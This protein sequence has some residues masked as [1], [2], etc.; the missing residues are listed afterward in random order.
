MLVEHVARFLAEFRGQ[1]PD[2]Q[3]VGNVKDLGIPPAWLEATVQ[4]GV[5]TWVRWRSCIPDAKRL[6]QLVQEHPEG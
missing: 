4:S 1:N 3:C 5:V 2:E 6:I